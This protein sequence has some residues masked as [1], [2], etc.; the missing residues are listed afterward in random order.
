VPRAAL[1]LHGLTIR[2]FRG[3][4]AVMGDDDRLCAYALR[5]ALAEHNQDDECYVSIMNEIA[6]DESACIACLLGVVVRLLVCVCD[7][8]AIAWLEREL[9]QILDGVQS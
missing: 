8:D 1:Y 3:R 9:L 6:D 5:L 4:A 7:D 2:R